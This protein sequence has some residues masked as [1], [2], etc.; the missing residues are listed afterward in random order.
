MID[1]VELR[2]PFGTPYTPEFQTLRRE[3]R[4]TAADPFRP[5]K[6][7]VNSGDLRRFGYPFILHSEAR[8]GDHDHKLEFIDSAQLS[9]RQMARQSQRVFAI[10]ATELGVMRIDLAADIRGVAVSWFDHHTRIR[11][12]RLASD[13]NRIVRYGKSDLETLTYG[14]R[15]NCFRIYNKIAEWQTQYRKLSRK[16]EAGYPCFE[17]VFGYPE[18]GVVLT[19][20]E[21]QIAGGRVPQHIGTFGRLTALPEFNPFDPLELLCA[22]GPEP[23]ADEVGFEHYAIGKFIQSLIRQYGLHRARSWLNKHANRN[24]QR[25]LK[26][27]RRF[28]PAE[29]DGV[30]QEKLL[31]VY[32]ASV[33]RQLLQREL[34]A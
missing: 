21:R 14:A 3:I 25:L 13:H 26:R 6:L 9:Y 23:G 28:I 2:V 1:K 7:Y 22:A 29:G 11:W 8:Y 32:R 5:S 24:G 12:K 16:A 15:P 17:D 34:A 18:N 4:H 31:Q 27:Y 10:D 20:V 33:T 30:T 19:R